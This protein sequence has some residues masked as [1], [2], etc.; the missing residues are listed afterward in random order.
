MRLQHAL[1]CYDILRAKYAR[2]ASHFGIRTF[3]AAN[4]SLIHGEAKQRGALQA[5][6]ALYAGAEQVIHSGT[7]ITR[8]EMRAVPILLELRLE[9]MDTVQIFNNANGTY[10][11]KLSGTVR[12]REKV[13]AECITRAIVDFRT[14]AGQS[15]T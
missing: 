13:I 11:L 3:S 9:A 7:G 4:A 15:Q 1:D 5:V 10:Q 14:R 12:G 8:D 6:D 2:L